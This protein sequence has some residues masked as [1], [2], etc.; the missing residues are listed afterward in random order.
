MKNLTYII[1]KP[2]VLNGH[3]KLTE[4]TKGVYNLTYQA[5]THQ[6]LAVL[7]KKKKK[8]TAYFPSKGKSLDA[9]SLDSLISLLFHN[10]GLHV[11]DKT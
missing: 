6:G 10:W 3:A 1:E 2:I 9:T 8:W 7:R 11:V 4:L 5:G